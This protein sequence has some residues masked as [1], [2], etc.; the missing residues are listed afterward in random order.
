MVIIVLFFLYF[1]YL[2]FNAYV[3]GGLL[4]DPLVYVP[5]PLTDGNST[6]NS[7]TTSTTNSTTNNTANTSNNSMEENQFS[8]IYDLSYQ[9]LSSIPS[10]IPTGTVKIILDGNSIADIFN[11]SFG[12]SNLTGVNHFSLKSNNLTTVSNRAF[13]GFLGLQT[14]T[15]DTNLLE[16]LEIWADDVPSLTELSLRENSM[17]AMPTFIGHFN[18]L[19]KLHLE[20]NRI[21]HIDPHSFENISNIV[22]LYFFNNRLTEFESSTELLLL[23]NLELIQN[24]MNTMPRLE[25]YYRRLGRISL[26]ENNVDLHSILEFK[27]HINMSSNALRSFGLSRNPSLEGNFS[28]VLQYLIDTFPRIQYISLRGLEITEIPKVNYNAVN[29][30]S[31]DLSENPIE[32]IS[33]KDLKIIRHAEKVKLVLQN[34]DHPLSIDDPFPYLDDGIRLEFVLNYTALVCEKFCWMMKQRYSTRP[35]E[36]FTNAF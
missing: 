23:N 35:L 28:T 19:T 11:N 31:L 4:A 3:T 16:E 13:A 30:L 12:N 5:P 21:S 20:N 8:D 15:L 25:G 26:G 22:Q 27:K 36:F 17:S 14:L 32:T 7:T 33:A 24:R 34:M 29:G 6:T 9:N 2:P 10:D 18:S 1:R